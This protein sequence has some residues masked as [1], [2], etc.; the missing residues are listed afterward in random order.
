MRYAPASLIAW[1]LVAPFLAA[2]AWAEGGAGPSPKLPCE[3]PAEFTTPSVPLISVAA[4]LSA[5]R[6]VEVL[7]L[8]SGSTVGEVGTSTGKAFAGKTPG[9]SFPYRMIEALHALRPDAR[10]KLTVAG[11][12]NMSAEEMLT[13][14]HKRLGA[15]RYDL[16]I[17]QTGTVEAVRGL[18]P[19]ALHDVLE[20]GIDEATEKHVDV[21]LVDPQFSRFLRANIDLEPYEWV[22]RQTADHEG[23][24]LFRRLALTQTWVDSGEVDLERVSREQRDKTIGLLNVCLGR[25]LA[26][27]VLAGAAMP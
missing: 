19:E 25:A 18:R 10:F 5:G 3:I 26:D 12:R 7:A 4:A 13:E 8:G 1:L 15:H 23:V 24:G 6:P 14:L 9:A 20:Q 21:L 22:M 2:P 16:L 27:Y 11:G 17:W